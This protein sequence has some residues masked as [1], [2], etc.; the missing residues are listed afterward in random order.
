MKDVLQQ[1]IAV[2]LTCYNRKQKTLDFLESLTSQEYFKKLKIDI[3]LMDDA[4]TDGTQEAVKQKYPFVDVVTGNGIL[5]WAGGMRAIWRRAMSVKAYDLF[6]IF[7]DDVVLFDDSLERLLSAYAASG[8]EGNII[9]GSTLSPESKKLTY[10]GNIHYNIK[11]AKYYR[12]EPD[13]VKA[14]ICHS[15]NANIL[16]VD[17]AAVD[18]IGIFPDNY[19]H[20]LADFDYTLTAF[21]SGLNVA[22]APGYYGYCEDDHGANWLSGKNSLKKR[23]AYLYSPKG[24]AYKEYLYYIRK[25]FPA[26]YMISFIKLWLKTFFPILWDKFKLKEEHN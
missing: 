26:D 19:V 12:A 18:Q 14:I 24:L 8:R 5:F 10:G 1:N 7:N 3:H 25:H 21:K 6:L 15:C 4:S 11:R 2:L 17:K 20:C 13:A 23:I 9:V 22:I 16:L